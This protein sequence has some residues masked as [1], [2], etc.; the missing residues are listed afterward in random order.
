MVAK[1]FMFKRDFE[2]FVS[3]YERNNLSP[4]GSAALAG[5]PH[6]IDRTIV[7]SELGFAGC[8]QGLLSQADLG[9]FAHTS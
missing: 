7:A 3:S 5:T 4:L 8:T 2:R 1:A 9:C 6:K